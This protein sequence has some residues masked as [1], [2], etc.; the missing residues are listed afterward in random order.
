MLAIVAITPTDNARPTITTVK[1]F[2]NM[3][4]PSLVGVALLPPPYVIH[5]ISLLA[6][7]NYFFKL[8]SKRRSSISE[9]ISVIKGII[10][11]AHIMV[12]IIILVLSILAGN[13]F[14]P[15]VVHFTR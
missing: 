9:T 6:V 14:P 11:A 4:L 1:I 15:Y 3:M 13:Y 8:L 10:T 7:V 2:S 5:I 12:R